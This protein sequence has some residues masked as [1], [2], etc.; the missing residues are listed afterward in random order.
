LANEFVHHFD[1][2]PVHPDFVEA[3][4]V[5]EDVSIDPGL[6]L[7]VGLDFGRTPAAV[8]G[9][10]LPSGRWIITHELSTE[11]M[12]AVNFGPLLRETIAN[13]EEL[14][15]TMGV[16]ITG[17]PAGE[18]HAQTR[19]ET[20]FQVLAETGVY[21]EPAETNDFGVRVNSLDRLLT[22]LSEGYPA[23]LIHPRCTTLIRGL[24]GDYHY[25]RMQVAGTSVTRTGRTKTSQV[26]PVRRFTICCSAVTETC[27]LP[28]QSGRPQTR[29][30]AA[31]GL[32][33]CTCLSN[34]GPV[35]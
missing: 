8:F 33:R 2:Q 7:L 19:S 28:L 26:T 21:A 25:R 11:N 31:P 35:G 13:D 17:D 1:G 30:W 6:P 15:N 22:K 3:T 16:H 32:R 9:Q 18:Q 5:R 23:I 14:Q 12:S 29:S 27:Y 20:V 4:H 10:K 34:P 24:A